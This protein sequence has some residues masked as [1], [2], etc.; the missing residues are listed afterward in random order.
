MR[1]ERFHLITVGKERKKGFFPRDSVPSN[2]IQSELAIL[3]EDRGMLSEHKR[4]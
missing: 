2:Q 4:E 1:C 3:I